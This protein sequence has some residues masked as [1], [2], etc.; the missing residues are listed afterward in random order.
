MKAELTVAV[1]ISEYLIRVRKSFSA[2][3]FESGMKL[4]LSYSVW[5]DATKTSSDFELCL[6]TRE[7]PDL[8]NVGM[9]W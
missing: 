9:E 7:R 4:Q 2:D 5:P 3:L 1:T 8:A 6:H